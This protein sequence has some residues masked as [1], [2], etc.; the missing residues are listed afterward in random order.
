MAPSPSADA[1]RQSLRSVPVAILCKTIFGGELSSLLWLGPLGG[2][3][4]A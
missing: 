4:Q 1:E 2:G 3:A